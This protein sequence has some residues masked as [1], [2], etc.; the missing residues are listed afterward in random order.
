MGDVNAPVE[1]DHYALDSSGSDDSFG[2]EISDWIN[3]KDG[4]PVGKDGFDKENSFSSVNDGRNIYSTSSSFYGMGGLTDYSF[5]AQTVVPV[6]DS[7]YINAHL[8]E[9]SAL[10][11]VEDLN[12]A[13]KSIQEQETIIHS[14]VTVTY[15]PGD[16]VFELGDT[17]DDFYII[18]AGTSSG[19]QH[20]SAPAHVEVVRDNRVLTRLYRGQ[21]FG[22]MQFLTRQPRA[23][24]ASIRVPA[25]LQGG[26]KIAR[27]SAAHFEHWAFFRTMLIVRAIPFL[28]Q[29]PLASRLELLALTQVRHF[30][31]GDCIIKQGDVGDCFYILLDGSVRIVEEIASGHREQIAVLRAGHCF[32]EMALA[33]NE[34]RIASVYSQEL[35]TCLMLTKDAFQKELSVSAFSEVLTD[36]LQ[37]RQRTRRHRDTVRKPVH[38]NNNSHYSSDWAEFTH[39]SVSAGTNSLSSSDMGLPAGHSGIDF[40][41]TSTTSLST[42]QTASNNKG[43]TSDSFVDLGDGNENTTP[44]TWNRRSSAANT[45]TNWNNRM[46]ISDN[47]VMMAN[48]SPPARAT[49]RTLSEPLDVPVTET[50]YLSLSKLET[51]DKCVNGKYMLEREIGHGS[52]GD[53]WQVLDLSTKRQFAMKTLHRQGHAGSAFT[54]IQIDTSVSDVIGEI[55]IMKKLR[56]D[57]VVKLLEV[58]DDP[59]AHKLYLIQELMEGPLLPDTLHSAPLAPIM[60][61]RYFR[62]IVRGVH[63]LHAQGI[64]HRDIKPQNIL[65]S[66]GTAKIGDLGT[67]VFTGGHGGGRSKFQG[68]PAYTAPELNLPHKQRSHNFSIMPCIDLFAMGA[69]LYCMST[70]HPPWMADTELGLA[71]KI[72]NLEPR[73]SPQTD[74]HLKFLVLRLLEKDWTR[75]AD[76][77]AVVCDAWV[78]EEGSD[79]LFD[80]YHGNGE[81]ENEEDL[82]GEVLDVFSSSD[83]NLPIVRRQFEFDL[84]ALDARIMSPASPVNTSTSSPNIEAVKANEL[85]TVGE[86]ELEADLNA[87]TLDYQWTSLPPLSEPRSFAKLPVSAATKP[88]PAAESIALE[89]TT[90]PL[91]LATTSLRPLPLADMSTAAALRRQKRLQSIEASRVLAEPEIQNAPVK[92]SLPTALS[93]CSTRHLQTEGEKKEDDDSDGDNSSCPSEESNDSDY[94]I[95]SSENQELADIFGALERINSNP[96][97]G[98]AAE[99]DCVVCPD[100]SISVAD[101]SRGCVSPLP[102]NGKVRGESVDVPTRMSRL[103]STTATAAAPTPTAICTSACGGDLAQ[104]LGVRYSIS[105]AQG[106]RQVMEDRIVTSTWCTAASGAL[107]HSSSSTSSVLFALFDGHGGDSAAEALRKEVS[108]TLQAA[109]SESESE[110]NETGSMGG[111]SGGSSRGCSKYVTA[112]RKT[113]AR[114]DCMLLTQDYI[115]LRNRKEQGVGLVPLQQD[116]A[117]TTGLMVLIQSQPLRTVVHLAN[118]GDCRAVI[119]SRGESTQLSVDHKPID[120]C[121]AD[122]INKAGGH[123]VNGRVHGALGVSRAFGDIRYKH[124]DNGILS[125]LPEENVLDWTEQ[126]LWNSQQIVTSEPQVITRIVVPA[127]EFIIAATDG[128]WDLLSNEAA[129]NFVRFQLLAHGDLNLAAHQLLELAE[130]RAG[131]GGADNMSVAIVALNQEL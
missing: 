10:C 79:P 6:P 65:I 62:D 70:G 109:L 125:V 35:C 2:G 20:G 68:T 118:V 110:S 27:I 124:V 113:C 57:Y 30:S 97:T 72:Q 16:F 29:L 51:G 9:F 36:L 100:G 67:A 52:F 26:V 63:Y 37:R 88:V 18:V 102:E 89:N 84:G 50:K 99:W 21:Y 73:L 112:F 119:C 59:K 115:H 86:T 87:L 117:G 47:A 14:M 130:E 19:Q 49:R 83:M 78:T 41:N 42:V 121:E 44:N 104:Q 69:T 101:S 53:V 39:V 75:R 111:E 61:R 82:E 31:E 93:Y 108:S 17:T 40:A 74:P 4:T 28:N 32:G 128:L 64:V 5:G 1:H 94:G 38:S 114:L 122:R 13:T 90:P 66:N 24:N 33:N 91:S 96:S 126:H 120:A 129:I 3:D 23:R 77:D 56:N 11:E 55:A 34:S 46:S 60:C 12:F 131:P 7:V 98:E 15:Q 45:D 92:T 107:L 105:Q 76:M 43:W 95:V 8:D 58:I 123:V 22:Q 106:G 103:Q 80:D 127:D 25:T 116:Y 85:E 48:R 71:D 54:R 81:S